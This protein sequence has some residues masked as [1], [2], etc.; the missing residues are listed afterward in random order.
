LAKPFVQLFKTPRS[1]YVFDV[2][3]NEML[4]VSAESFDF[5]QQCMAGQADIEAAGI[6]EIQELIREGY[7]RTESVVQEIQHPYTPYLKY[8]LDRK[9]EKITL[10]V[11]Q[12]CNLR[13]KYCVYSENVNV[14]QRSHSNRRMSWE[15]AKNGIDFLWEHSVD[16]P[17][18]NIGFYGGEPLLE[19]SLIK[20]ATEY[21]KKIF[22]GKKL[23]F[24]IT[25]NGTLL[26]DEII[27]FLVR[28][29][30]WLTIS[31]DGPQEI[32]DRNRVFSSGEGS[33]STIM[34]N[35]KRI[36]RLAPDYAQ[37]IMFSMVMDPQNDFD[38]INEIMVGLDNLNSHTFLA[39][40]VDREYDDAEVLFS[41][42]YL[43]KSYYQ[44][45]LALLSI[46]GRYPIE[47]VSAI[48]KK[49]SDIAINDARRLRLPAPLR[50]IDVPSG[51]CI[52]GQLRLLVNVD[53]YFF[54]C[55]RVSENSEAMC[56]GSLNNGFDI[57][58]ARS[59]LNVGSIT[60]DAC[61]RCWCF[62]QCSICA[63]KADDGSAHLSPRIKLS[64]CREIRSNAYVAMR[65]SLLL[66]EATQLYSQQTRE[67]FKP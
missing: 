17:R 32:H 54:P 20:C 33:F 56:I 65:R 61:K 19:F 45:F 55:E 60:P 35:I 26:T 64:H 16:S 57:P 44:Q 10:Q 67:E 52:P 9:I 1:Q 22:R 38:C 2:N 43:W 49:I 48:S 31:L 3:K 14:Q 18:V 7:L 34:K 27:D 30:V 13:C 51:P 12:G 46:L 40:I 62:R 39:S 66:A 53:G 58:K 23:S 5:L 63:K 15:T 11:T 42:E 28:E 6:E 50:P 47:N 36:E 4:P 25:T 21:A 8:F 24:S 59:L 29:E 37:N 41:Q